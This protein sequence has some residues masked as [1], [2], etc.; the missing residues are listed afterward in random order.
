M[1]HSPQHGLGIVVREHTSRGLSRHSLHL[2]KFVVFR[3]AIYRPDQC[4]AVLA[5]FLPELMVL[6]VPKA[7]LP[8]S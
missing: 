5:C 2:Q 6:E 4:G 8:E 1:A 3:W 7:N